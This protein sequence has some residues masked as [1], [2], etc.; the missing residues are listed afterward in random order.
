MMHHRLEGDTNVF[1]EESSQPALE[2]LLGLLPL[3]P[4]TQRPR[5]WQQPPRSMSC[6]EDDASTPPPGWA[7]QWSK[8]WEKHYW[9]N[10]KTGEQSW[11]HPACIVAKEE[12][13]RITPPH[14]SICEEGAASSEAAASQEGEAAAKARSQ[15]R[16]G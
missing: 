6:A 7:K 11:E 14:N 16:A 10:S 2:I 13:K 9:F 3:P 15:V 4:A 1:D 8:K 12:D 5:S